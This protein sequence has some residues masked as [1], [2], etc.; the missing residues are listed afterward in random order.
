[1]KRRPPEFVPWD[2]DVARYNFSANCGPAAFAVITETEVCRVMRYF[3]HFEHSPWTTLTHMRRAFTDAG[4]QIEVQRQ[5]LPVR[6]VVLIQ[7]LG[8]WTKTNF[9]SRWSLPHTHW[10]AVNRGWVFDHTVGEWQ[11]LKQWQRDTAAA[12]ISEIPQ[13]RGW[14]VKYGVE[15]ISCQT[16]WLGSAGTTP[17]SS[18]PASAFSLSS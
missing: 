15:A 9:F 14:A 1:M 6:G 13:A 18:S 11:T 3:A 4:W 10:I 7:W 5:A 17:R 16:A 12:F 8:P 2:I